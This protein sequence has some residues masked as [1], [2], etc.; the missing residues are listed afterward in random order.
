MK[1]KF[2]TES[3]SARS[4]QNLRRSAAT[5]STGNCCNADGAS[6]DIRA[7]GKPNDASRATQSSEQF[8]NAG[9]TPPRT[10]GGSARRAKPRARAIRPGTFYLP[11][12]QTR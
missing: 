8:Q 2:A 3:A 5:F 4:I 12:Q 10:P 9:G 7:A 1:Q 11:A 6:T